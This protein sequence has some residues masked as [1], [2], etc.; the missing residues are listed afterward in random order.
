[1]EYKE[2]K[3]FIKSKNAEQIPLEYIKRSFPQ[4]LRQMRFKW[5]YIKSLRRTPLFHSSSKKAKAT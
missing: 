5:Y 3:R 4:K 1:L 2:R